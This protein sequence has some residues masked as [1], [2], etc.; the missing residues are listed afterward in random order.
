M[1]FRREPDRVVHMAPD[2]ELEFLDQVAA[3]IVVLELITTGRARPLDVERFLRF[4]RSRLEIAALYLIDDP[5]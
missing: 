4:A 2:V 3:A 1:S 5:T